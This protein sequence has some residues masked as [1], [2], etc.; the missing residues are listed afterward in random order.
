MTTITADG[1]EQPQSFPGSILKEARDKKDYSIEYVAGRLHLRVRIIELLEADEYKQLPEPVFVKG[2]IRAY[3]KLL[4]IDDVP[5]LEQY[6]AHC[7][8]VQRPDRA[9]WQSQ[10]EVNKGIHLVRW[11]T[12][13]SLLVVMVTVGMWWHKAKDS[14]TLSKSVP[15]EAMENKISK[16]ITLTDLNKMHTIVELSDKDNK[17]G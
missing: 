10:R 14:L 11:F 4:D 1:I 7:K 9:L 16:K 15:A 13:I 12:V 6:K 17:R 3:A 2:Y 5:L 8:N